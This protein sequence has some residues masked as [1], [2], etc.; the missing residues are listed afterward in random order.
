MRVRALGD[1]ASAMRRATGSEH[2]REALWTWVDRLA[3]GLDAVAAPRASPVS[4]QP[5]RPC[6]AVDVRSYAREGSRVADVTGAQLDAALSDL[7]DLVTIMTGSSELLAGRTNPEAL[8]ARVDAAV[9]QLRAVRCDVVLVSTLRASSPL[10]PRRR[11]ERSA[12]FTSEL[13]SIA[14]ARG[15][16][17]VDAWTIPH[18]RARPFGALERVTLEPTGH[19]MLARRAIEALGVPYRD[20][21]PPPVSEPAGRLPG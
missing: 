13:W 20:G 11:V 12:E 15:A 21:L 7:P 18:V 5:A 19:R 3:I 4:T 1:S 16:T 9:A 6:P 14:R 8:A 17:V 2:A 10:V